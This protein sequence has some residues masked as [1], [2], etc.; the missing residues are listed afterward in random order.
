MTSAEE[1]NIQAVSPESGVPRTAVETR[2]ASC[3]VCANAA[4]GSHACLLVESG[5][6][7]LVDPG[8]AVEAGQPLLELHTDTPDAVA[9][10]LAALDG[11]VVVSDGPAP[12]RPALIGDTLRP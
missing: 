12:P 5:I 3:V 9:G 11:N 1:I 10:A 2:D 7:L 4:A 8:D 6:R